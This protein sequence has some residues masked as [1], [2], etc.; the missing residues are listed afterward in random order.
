MSFRSPVYVRKAQVIL[1][2]TNVPE[3]TL[4]GYTHNALFGTTRNP[5]DPRLTPGGSSG[6]AVAA[7]A[8]GLGPLAIG[9]DGGAL[10]AGRQGMRGSSASNPRPDALRAPPVC[11][12]SSTILK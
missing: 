1:G 8:A 9:T 11:P 2:K 5:W 7:V 6:G 4:Q 3:F 12:S 10:Y